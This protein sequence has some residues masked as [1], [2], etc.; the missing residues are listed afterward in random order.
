MFY[1]EFCRATSYSVRILL[2]VDGGRENARPLHGALEKARSCVLRRRTGRHATPHT[3]NR[4][5][6][7]ALPTTG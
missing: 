7:R 6:F 5:I 2:E 3:N 4:L 1:S